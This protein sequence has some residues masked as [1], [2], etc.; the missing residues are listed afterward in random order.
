MLTGRLPKSV[1]GGANVTLTAAVARCN[2]LEF[3]GAIAAN[4]QVI[5]PLAAQ[6]WTVFNNT[7]G[8]FTLTVVG[9][10]GTGS[11]VGQGKRAIV[12]SDGTNV[13]RASADV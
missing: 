8:A 5:V 12:Y 6:Q 4:I 10:T 3:T 11:T 9:A 2:I 13:V 1:A 7:S